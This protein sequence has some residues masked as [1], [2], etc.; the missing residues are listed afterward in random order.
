MV[1]KLLSLFYVEYKSNHGSPSKNLVF[2]SKDIPYSGYR[3]VFEHKCFE[4][5]W[6]SM[7]QCLY[8]LQIDEIGCYFKTQLLESIH[9]GAFELAY[10][11]FV[12][13]CD[14]LWRWVYP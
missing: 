11:G 12:K 3:R 10:A 5:F 4:T 6:L 2:V 7:I 13:M 1:L 14:M 9:R 8:S